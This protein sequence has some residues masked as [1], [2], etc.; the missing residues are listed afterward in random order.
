MMECEY[1]KPGA[2]RRAATTNI[3]RH[4]NELSIHRRGNSCASLEHLEAAIFQDRYSLEDGRIRLADQEHV[5][6]QKSGPDKTSNRRGIDGTGCCKATSAVPD[7]ATPAAFLRPR[8]GLVVTAATGASASTT[9]AYHCA[10]RTPTSNCTSRQHRVIAAEVPV[11]AKFRGLEADTR[12]ACSPSIGRLATSLP[13]RSAP[14]LT[15]KSLR[16][17]RMITTTRARMSRTVISGGGSHCA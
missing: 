7:E 13:S 1:P 9:G 8:K 10:V 17:S 6:R 11:K 4:G 2:L 5:A 3:L 12:V 15:G 16:V 14:K